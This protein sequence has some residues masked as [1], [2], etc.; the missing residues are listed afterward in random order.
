MKTFV[1]YKGKHMQQKL[2]WPNKKN[3]TEIKEL[4]TEL[5]ASLDKMTRL[6]KEIVNLWQQRFCNPTG[7]KRC[8]SRIKLSPTI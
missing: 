4:K 3:A 6:E 2:L 1:G 5:Q 8:P 7:K